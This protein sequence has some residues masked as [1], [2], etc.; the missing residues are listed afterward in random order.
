MGNF[1]Q[2]NQNT[3]PKAARL[4]LYSFLAND[5]ISVDFL[6]RGLPWLFSNGKFL[7]YACSFAAFLT[8]YKC[9]LSTTTYPRCSRSLW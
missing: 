5:D 1:F 9:P 8:G 7:N 6:H 2:S 4:L 3:D